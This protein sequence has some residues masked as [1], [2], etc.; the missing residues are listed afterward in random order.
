[1]GT[2]EEGTRVVRER[3]L[4]LAGLIHDE[5]T[6]RGENAPPPPPITFRRDLA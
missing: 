2:G 3:V 4:L 6:R 1:V 5:Q